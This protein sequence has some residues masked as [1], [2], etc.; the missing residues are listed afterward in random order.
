MKR[1]IAAF[2]DLDRTL[3]DVNSANLWAKHELVKRNI[4]LSQFARATFW[5]ILYHLSVIDIERAFAEAVGHYKGRS[6]EELREETRVW[7]HREVAHRLRPGARDALHR[8]RQEGNQLVILTSASCFEAEVAATTWE[9]DHWLANQ[10][11]TDADG[12]LTGTFERP[13][14]YGPGKVARATKWAEEHDVDLE[15]SY[16]YSDSLTDLPMLAH[17]GHARVVCPDPRLRREAKK[18]AWPI[19]DW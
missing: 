9:V 17:V 3:I 5:N 13:L 11:P 6:Y 18:R 2:F 14:C 19:L 10:F 1:N 12:R 4:T 7:F 16:F 8:H 15:S